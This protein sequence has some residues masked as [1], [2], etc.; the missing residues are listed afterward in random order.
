MHGRYG[1]GLVFGL[2]AG[3]KVLFPDALGH[4]GEGEGIQSAAHM[5]ALIAFGKAA[6]EELIER[7]AGDDA[8]LAEAGNRVGETPIGDAHAHAALNDLG[9]LHH[10]WILSQSRKF[11][12]FISR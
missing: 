6:H 5:S 3:D 9:K 12:G 8:E 7:G 1:I 4:V 2:A 10:L 11:R